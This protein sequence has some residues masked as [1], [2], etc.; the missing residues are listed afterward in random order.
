M[1]Q[2]I[3]ILAL[4]II[5][6]ASTPNFA[7]ETQEV[8]EK[9]V[10][11]IES[12]SPDANSEKNV[13][14]SKDGTD[15]EVAGKAIFI[16]SESADKEK[17]ISVNVNKA[18]KDGKEVSTFEV[19]ID[20]GTNKEV[21]AWEDS[22]EGIPASV[23]NQLKAHGVDIQLFRTDDEMT[24][25]VDAA[26]AIEKQSRTVDVNVASEINDGVEKR[27]VELTI[28]EDGN[29]QKMKWVD[30]GEIP[31]EIQKTLD[32]L[33]I[34]VNVL[35]G[36]EGTGDY[37]IEI[38][39]D[40]DHA[41]GHSSE[42]EVKVYKIEL[43]KDEE[44]SDE[45]K[46]ELEQYGVDI[47]QLINDAKEKK[48]GDE[49]VRIKKQIRIEKK[50]LKSNDDH[51]LHIIKLKDGEQLP[52]EVKQVLDKHN[53]KLEK[54]GG[55]TKEKRVMK[56][57]DE[58]GNT[59]V[60]EWDGEGEMPAEMKKHMEKMEKGGMGLLNGHEYKTMTPN[61]AQFGVMIQDA[62]NGIL[63][64][65]IV[66]NSA[67][68]KVGIL[69]GDVITHV[70][71]AQ[72]NTIESLISNLSDKVPGDQVEVSFLRD[73]QKKTVVA[74]LTAPLHDHKV[75]MTTEVEISECNTDNFTG[76]EDVDLLF[77]TSGNNA[78]NKSIVIVRDIE[79]TVKTDEVKNTSKEKEH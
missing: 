48:T 25:T 69:A 44:I 21:I 67:A 18:L 54:V 52:D 37:E 16:G 15:K 36:G 64:N 29:V 59:K 50:D 38:E 26:N 79:T 30:E 4:G 47:D 42:H 1:K 61:K 46:E 6:A 68:A 49:P 63:V 22:G 33:G 51:D 73:D 27:T 11:I 70:D 9:K 77:K 28:E 43:D 17:D 7:Q 12:S 75:E 65:D 53:I 55:K 45:L 72:I 60:I 71:G 20:D 74:T 78:R 10:M 5:L 24:V 62:E 19:T 14:I 39:K 3:F 35:S 34:D 58:N 8:K 66:D 31:E 40:G 41:H 2:I 57:I 32:D 56:F 76:D 13:W 23:E